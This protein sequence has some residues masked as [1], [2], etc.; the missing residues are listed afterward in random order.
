MVAISGTSEAV[1]VP[2]VRGDAGNTDNDGVQGFSNNANHVGVLGVNPTGGAGVKGDCPAGDG[3]QGFSHHPDH[4]GVI[5]SNTSGVGVRGYSDGHDG[6]QGFT[7]AAGKAGVVGVCD[8]NVLNANGILG[9]SMLG[10]GVV[11][12]CTTTSGVGVLGVGGRVAG[13]FEGSV[14]VTRD[15]VVSGDVK[16]T[17]GDVAEQFDVVTEVP[18]GSVVCLDD[19]ARVEVCRR[20]YDRRVA[21]IVSGLGDRKPAVVLDR[22]GMGARRPVAVVGKAWCLADAGEAPI[23]VGDLLTTSTLPGHAM[24]ARDS[25]AAFGAVIGKALTPLRTGRGQVLVL[26]GLG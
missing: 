17:G 26:V 7:K 25:G 16:L 18:A 10:S 8:E 2:G 9:R 4:S 5:G 23:E 20:A 3:V 22:T 14:E 21:G 15:L 13:R 11:G 12:Q 19:S 1:G 6:I 24:V